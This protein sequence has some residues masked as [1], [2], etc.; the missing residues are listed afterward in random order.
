MAMK[1]ISLKQV[2]DITH[3]KYV[4]DPAL[5]DTLITGVVH[6]NRNVLPGNIFACIV[7]ERV[8]GHSFAENAFSRGACACI[9][10]KELENPAG[11]YIMVESTLE[12]I[13]ALGKY[14][15]SILNIPVIGVIGSVGKTTAKEMIAAALSVKYNV[16]K[17]PANFNTEL[18]VPLTLLTIQEDHDA[19]VI[20]MGIS[21]FGEMSRLADM[22]RPNFAVMTNIGACHL[23]SLGDLNGVLKAKSEVFA[24]MPAGSTAILNGDDALLKEYHPGEGIRKLTFGLSQSGNDCY[25]YDVK[26]I[27]TDSVS[28][29]ISFLDRTFEA[30]LPAFGSHLILG[31]MPALMI[32]RL[33]GV[34][35][36]DIA[37]GFSSYRPVGGRANV[38]DTG[39]IRLINDCY[40]ANPVSCGASI[41][42]LCSLNARHVAILGDMKELGKN[43]AQLHYD[44]GIHAAEKGV[45]CLICIGE[46]AAHLHRGFLSAAPNTPAYHFPT[47]EDALSF[48]SIIL[49]KGDAVLVKASHSMEFEKIVDELMQ[50]EPEELQPILSDKE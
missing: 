40:N 26:T 33:L 47:K 45:D 44:L 37:E 10:E 9:T 42:S 13:K 38:T 8:D 2:T 31:A 24:Y 36:A 27:G 6:D 30:E 20:E 23:E 21:E 11:P 41:N 34:D 32:A 14:Y 5:A 12:A 18:G 39:F 3:G 15:R 28:G 48:L 35:D 16:L 43:S 22:V 19:A 4:G 49:N 17:T 29:R 1:P 46:E 50:L 7:G 25:A